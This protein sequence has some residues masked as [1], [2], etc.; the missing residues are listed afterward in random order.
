MLWKIRQADSDDLP[1]IFSSWLKSFRNYS[2]VAGVPNTVYYDKQ[3]KLISRLLSKPTTIAIIACDPEDAKTIY[4]YAVAEVDA[5]NMVLHYFYVKH[6]LRGFGIAK[7]LEAELNTVNVTQ[8]VYSSKTRHVA[9]R[10]Y[11]YDP[12]TLW[13]HLNE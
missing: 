1:F 11:I 2:S 8:T 7:A 13:R 5:S 10:N 4:G 6:P 9:K 3:H 12:Y